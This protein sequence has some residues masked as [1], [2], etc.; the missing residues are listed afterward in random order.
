[1]RINTRGVVPALALAWGLAVA[2]ALALDHDNLDE[3]RPLRIEDA[4][5]IPKG[6]IGVESG[7][8]V[9]DRRGDGSG[10]GASLRLL[11]GAWYNTH[12]ELGGDLAFEGSAAAPTERDGAATLGVLYNFNTESLT[13]PAFSVRA[14]V[15]APSG[16][17]DAGLDASGGLIMTRTF[18]R[19][20][21]HLN[22]AYTVSGSSPAGERR[23]VYDAAAGLS[24]PLGYP[25][26]FRETVIADVFTRQSAV[27]GESNTT[28]LEV[29][30]RHQ[31]SARVV[32]DGGVGSDVLGPDER[33]AWYA[34]AGLSVGW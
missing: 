26:R 24:Y 15:A 31:F 12:V 3:G 8:T 19:W 27:S 2:P 4:Y 22:A 21:T 34:I 29:G 16:V 25:M 13:W 11:Y 20:R 14:E 6:E 1:M 30:L 9:H 5:P 10:Y 33:S 18:G 17:G 32:L 28:G 7:V 23:G